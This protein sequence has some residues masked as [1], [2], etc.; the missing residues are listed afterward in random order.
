MA[1]RARSI[2]DEVRPVIDRFV[3][4]LARILERRAV[5]DLKRRVLSEARGRGATAGR[6]VRAVGRETIRCYFPG[7]PNV[8][9][10]RFGM[11]CAAEHKNLPAAQK[12][13]Y[14]AARLAA[15]KKR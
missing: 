11:F 2:Q 6:R 12:A 15:D 13:K 7:C 8:A 3:A 1:R 4:Q 14:R 9:A 5:S 10:P